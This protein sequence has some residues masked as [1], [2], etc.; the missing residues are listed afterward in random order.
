V[1]G[2]KHPPDERKAGTVFPEFTGIA[3]QRFVYPVFFCRAGTTIPGILKRKK[4]N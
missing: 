1:A 2:V 4:T 3:G